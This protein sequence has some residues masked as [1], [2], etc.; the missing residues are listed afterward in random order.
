M[1]AEPSSEGGTAAIHRRAA[2]YGL[3]RLVTW[4]NAKWTHIGPVA[5]HRMYLNSMD[6]FRVLNLSTLELHLGF[7]MTLIHYKCKGQGLTRNNG[8]A[9]AGQENCCGTITPPFGKASKWA[10]SICC[11]YTPSF[12]WSWCLF[13]VS[14]QILGYDSLL[15]LRRLHTKSCNAL[16][17]WCRLPQCHVLQ[18]AGLVYGLRCLLNNSDTPHPIWHGIGD[19]KGNPLQLAL[20]FYWQAWRCLVSSGKYELVAIKNSCHIS[21]SWQASRD[22]HASQLVG[23]KPLKT[24]HPGFFMLSDEFTLIAK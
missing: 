5:D 18:G 10:Y 2:Q 8:E 20:H 12:S 15:Y 22:F 3:S 21:T 9:L 7:S 4:D 16:R 23:Q 14:I 19:P 24:R 13:S 11:S 6:Q 17:C 1:P